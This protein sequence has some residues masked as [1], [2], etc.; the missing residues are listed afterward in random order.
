MNIQAYP[1]LTGYAPPSERWHAIDTD[2]YDGAP[3]AGPQIV[4]TGAT[5]HEA[6]AD[7]WRNFIDADA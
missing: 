4:G 7:Y 3:D 2:T 5:A 6:L 1:D